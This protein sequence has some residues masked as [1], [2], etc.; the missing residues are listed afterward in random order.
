MAKAE[1]CYKELRRIGWSPQQ[2]RSILPNSLKT[3]IVVTANFREWLHIFQLRTAPAAHPQMREIMIPVCREFQHKF[4][5]V[6]DGVNH[7]FM[8]A[9][10]A[11]ACHERAEEDS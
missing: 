8:P 2:A 1:L 7:S 3:E 5:I 6:F 4:P 9:E 10:I 11:R